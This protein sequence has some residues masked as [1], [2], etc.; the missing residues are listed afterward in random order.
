MS[1]FGFSV[2]TGFYCILMLQAA[3]F[4][5]FVAYVLIA[6]IRGMMQLRASAAEAVAPRLPARRGLAIGRRLRAPV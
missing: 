5:V 1:D 4:I 6:E 2:W 3:G